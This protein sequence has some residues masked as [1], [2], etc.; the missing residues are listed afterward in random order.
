[1]DSEATVRR[2]RPSLAWLLGPIAT[3]LGWAAHVLG[4]G[5]SPSALIVVALAALLGMAA[6]IGKPGRLPGWGLL[7]TA[8]ITQQLLHFA[9][10]AFSISTGFDAPSHGHGQSPAQDPGTATQGQGPVAHDLHLLLYL[11][12]GAAL[13]TL[14]ITRQLDRLPARRIQRKP[15]DVRAGM[16]VRK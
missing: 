2:P 11:H 13:L 15:L 12:M 8:G 7:L 5:A 1:M 16:Q 4:G 10:A 6:A 3:G 14:V 9:F